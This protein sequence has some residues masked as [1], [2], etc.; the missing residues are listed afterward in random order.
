MPAATLNHIPPPELSSRSSLGTPGRLDL[1]ASSALWKMTSGGPLHL[2]V[3]LTTRKLIASSLESRLVAQNPS[4]GGF[5]NC[6]FVASGSMRTRPR[7][8]VAPL[9][10][11]DWQK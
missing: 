10:T 11:H 7:A 5:E 3:W 6:A 8:T 1:E 2:A 4:V 9:L